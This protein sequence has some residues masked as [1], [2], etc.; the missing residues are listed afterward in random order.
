[1]DA[2]KEALS[3]LKEA[4]R[5]LL[6]THQNVDADSL[7]SVLALT[8][9]LRQHDIDAIPIITDGQ[10]PHSLQFLPG[11]SDALLYGQDE[12]PDYDMLLMADCSD[13]TRLGRFYR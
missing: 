4:N 1:A 6:P 11:A 13:R 8:L 7:S 10:T 5:V 2:A 9:A 12:L 3:H